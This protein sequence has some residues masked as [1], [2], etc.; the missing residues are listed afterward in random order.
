M[1][2]EK[3]RQRMIESGFLTLLGHLD[4]NLKSDDHKQLF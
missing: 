4:L 1:D 3:M 2:L